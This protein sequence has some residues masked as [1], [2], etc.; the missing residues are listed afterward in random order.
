[1][2]TQIRFGDY[3]KEV[4]VNHSEISYNNL[5]PKLVINEKGEPLPY[6][7]PKLQLRAMDAYRLLT[8]YVSVR[9]ID[10]FKAVTPLAIYMGLFQ[11]FILNQ[12]ITDATIVGA[13]LFAV[14][15][16]LM[17]FMEGLKLGLMPFGEIIGNTLPKKAH[18]WVVLTITFLLGIGVTFAEP[19]IGA[20][21]IA[22]GIVDPTKAPYLYA[23]LTSYS[24]YLVLVVGLGVGLAAVL[25]TMRFIYNWSLKPMIYFS[26]IPTLLLTIFSQLNP[27]VSKIVG[28]A[29]DCGG[30]TTGP[31]TVP[32]V[33]ALGIGVSSAVGKGNS[34]LS[35]FGI[36]T[37]A[38]IF[39]ILGVIILGFFVA[40]TITPAEILIAVESAKIAS[41]QAQSSWSEVTPGVE[42]IMGLRAIVPLVLF[43]LV[44][45]Y[46]VLKEKIKNVGTIRYG[47]SLAVIGMIVFNLGLT[48][49]LTKLGDQ[50]G[51]LV[52]GAFTHIEKMLGSP[53]FAPALGI[54]TAILFAWCL[55]FGATLAEPALNAL[56][57][58]VENL[59][60]GAF[61]K[62]L[63]MYSVAIGVG[64]GIAVGVAKI[65][66]AIPLTY[67]LLPGYCVAVILT[68]LN[69][70]EYVNIAW[71]SAG[72]TT[73]P[74]T[75]PLV[76]AMGLGFA[77]AVGAIEGFGI[78]A[79][80]S[81]FPILAV[82]SCGLYVQ[83]KTKNDVV[84]NKSLGIEEIII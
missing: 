62:S 16:G 83:T 2:E 15:I 34:S 26:L 72:V 48:Y 49:G 46:L 39:P 75:V 74:V 7:P 77:N 3:L 81:L 27:E 53:L 33:L 41:S 52:P 67:I 24:G 10:Q 40:H 73:G 21:Q 30:V 68:Y 28:L 9:F 56:G 43:L 1:M 25:G 19:A 12:T 71:D 4:T 13:G 17:L 14:M 36:V 37:L 8:P 66:F 6:N 44:V 51:S 23:L 38:S 45:L 76:L 78:L 50:S 55:G 47:V 84:K 32:L 22:G 64:L 18:L 82:L 31:V 70:E 79:A 11:Y 80:A 69:S 29:W 61:K 57:M 59:T 65:I 20:L 58:T 54:I 5:A 42:I 35:G 60:N 63:L